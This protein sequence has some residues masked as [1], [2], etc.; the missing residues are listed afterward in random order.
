M[1]IELSV[2]RLE[3]C[4]GVDRKNYGQCDSQAVCSWFNHSAYRKSQCPV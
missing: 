4:M 3:I 1:G 2:Y